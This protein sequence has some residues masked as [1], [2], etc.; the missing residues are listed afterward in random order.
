MIICIFC[1]CK[2]LHACIAIIS[3]LLLLLLL[4]FYVDC[5]VGSLRFKLW[6]LVLFA[7]NADFI[8]RRRLIFECSFCLLVT[9][10]IVNL[11]LVIHILC[12]CVCFC[13]CRMLV[14]VCVLHFACVCFVELLVT[15]IEI[16]LQ[17][18]CSC[19]HNILRLPL[20]AAF[21]SPSC[22]VRARAL[23]CLPVSHTPLQSLLS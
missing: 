11:S 19:C 16:P 8:K 5:G 14:C 4:F 15:E 17:F 22:G 18:S 20:P 6:K 3:M 23:G 13:V 12:V 21:C 7:I 10:T 1:C 2:F 9:G